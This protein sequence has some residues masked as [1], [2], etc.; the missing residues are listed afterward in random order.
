MAKRLFNISLRPKNKI[1]K[2]RIFMNLVILNIFVINSISGNDYI[3]EIHLVIK[4][5]GTQNIT[6]NDYGGILPNEVIVN[7]VQRTGCTKNCYLYEDINNVT[8]KF[9]TAIEDC[10]FM[11]NHVYNIIEVDLS[12]FD[13]SNVNTMFCMFQ[14]CTNLEKV[15][16]GKINL[17]SLTSFYGLFAFCIN[18]RIVNLSYIDTSH[19]DNI[20]GMFDNCQK[21][22]YLDLSNF[23]TEGVIE[24]HKLFNNCK[25]LIYLNLNS[26][27]FKLKDESV[28]S[29]DIFY[30]TSSDTKFCINDAN[31]R[32]KLSSYGKISNCS[33]ICFK[34]NIKIDLTN[35]LCVES[36]QNKKYE[37]NNICLNECKI[38]YYPKFC[39]SNDCYEY[40]IICYNKTPEEYYFDSYSKS[41][42]KCYETCKSCFGEGNEIYNNCTECNNGYLFLND[43]LYET[44]CYNKCEYYY[45]FNE[46]N[47]YKC[48]SQEIC[49]NNYKLIIAKKKCI[50]NCENDNNYKYEYNLTCYINCPEETINEENTYICSKIE[51][52]E[53]TTSILSKTEN[54]EKILMS[55]YI[56][57][58]TYNYEIINEITYKN[59]DIASQTNVETEIEEQTNTFEKI[60]KKLIKGD[61][62]TEIDKGKDSVYVDRNF[63]YTVTSTKN[64]ENNKD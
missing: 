54:F 17:S 19:L 58:S 27:K 36:C 24:M 55:S 5:S 42:K 52:K 7:G 64:Q 59:I 63:I 53:I 48:T 16:F 56:D 6:S 23:N 62:T 44:N 32:E 34:K 11:F 1:K 9:N 37:E 25:S 26:T 2:Y 38:G 28:K 46:S 41:Y 3:S 22:I 12:D 47:K 10:T 30:N 14:A 20:A 35:K 50:D 18:L 60:R 57:L 43:S 29:E 21:I 33:D 45:Y 51:N 31:L 40:P 15:N 49:P 39:E 4:G 13:A 61:Y 8:L